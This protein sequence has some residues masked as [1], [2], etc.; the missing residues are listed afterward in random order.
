MCVIIYMNEKEKIENNELKAAWER[1]PDGAGY[2]IRENG[3]IFFKRGFM[4]F[5][6]YKE[7]I[8]EV[9]NHYDVMLHLR[10]STSDS[11]N[12]L[13]T[14]PYAIEDVTKIQGY[15]KM[16]ISMNGSIKGQKLKKGYNDTMSFIEEYKYLFE[17]M[18][19][20]IKH[21]SFYGDLITRISGTKWCM[22]TNN[23]TYTSPQFVEENGIKYSNL[24]HRRYQDIVI[25]NLKP[26]YIL[27]EDILATAQRDKKLINE[28]NCFIYNR[29][30]RG[31]CDRCTKCLSS[32]N[33][34]RDI[35][36]TI[37]ENI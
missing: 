10:I 34:L 35:R 37:K 23:A 14:H 21:F 32:A 29:C 13:Q 25:D 4:S 36:I 7:E 8:S 31:Y 24:F 12:K 2:S 27:E 30:S 1:N 19:K 22:M 6:E 17:T 15:T 16:A 3:K 9:L 18:L 11:I 26:K 5:D 28:I 33:T 20:D